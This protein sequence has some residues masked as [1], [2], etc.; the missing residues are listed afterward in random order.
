M[1]ISSSSPSKTPVEK[2]QEIETVVWCAQCREVVGAYINDQYGIYMDPDELRAQ[3][4]RCDSTQ[5]RRIPLLAA[6][7]RQQIPN[8]VH[9]RPVILEMGLQFLLPICHTRWDTVA[10][11]TRLAVN[12]EKAWQQEIK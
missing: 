7:V 2:Q 4:D 10:A 11:L 12:L 3:C 1:G 6:T 9:G 5:V 8:A